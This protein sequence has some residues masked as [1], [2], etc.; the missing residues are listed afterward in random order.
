M[1]VRGRTATSPH[2]PPWVRCWRLVRTACGLG[3]SSYTKLQLRGQFC[4]DVVVH[5][6]LVRVRAQ[7]DRVDLVLPLVLDPRLDQVGGEP[8]AVD[9]VLVVDLEPVEDGVQRRGHLLDA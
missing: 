6:E 1:A 9:E 4:S 5:R 2:E 7:P 8:P 3:T